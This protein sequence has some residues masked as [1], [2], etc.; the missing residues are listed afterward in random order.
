[1]F[2]PYK[3][4]TVRLCKS[5]MRKDPSA[6][7]LIKARAMNDTLLFFALE[8]DGMNLRYIEIFDITEKMCIS[9]VASRIEALEYVPHRMRNSIFPQA[10]DDIVNRCLEWIKQDITASIYLPDSIRASHRIL[11]Y[12]NSQGLIH[13]NESFFDP[14]SELFMV[15]V[16]FRLDEQKENYFITT[17]FNTFNEYY[18][19]LKGNLEGAYLREYRFDGIDLNEYNINGAVIDS[20]ILEKHGLYDGS[21]FAKYIAGSPNELVDDSNCTELSDGFSYLIPSNRIKWKWNNESVT[22][23]LCIHYVSDLHLWHR[24]T[25]IFRN[26]ATQ[27]EIEA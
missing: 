27:E 19:F 20:E 1:M 18:S 26:R 21:Y 4:Q 24:V 12:Q 23:S 6:F 3:L 10:S 5:A 15:K 14:A 7:R 25:Q 22:N 9:A 2:V 16:E 13:A 8:M 17:S 11:T